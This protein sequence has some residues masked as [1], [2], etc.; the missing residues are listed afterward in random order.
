VAAIVLLALLFATGISHRDADE[1]TP[2]GS[3]RSSAKP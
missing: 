3:A 2:G 1:A